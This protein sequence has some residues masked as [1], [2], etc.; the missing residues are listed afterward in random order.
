MTRLNT[1]L[2]FGKRHKADPVQDNKAADFKRQIRNTQ[3]SNARLR[4]R[5]GAQEPSLPKLSFLDDK[6]D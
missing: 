2:R 5:V 4:K 6:A 1:G 3:A